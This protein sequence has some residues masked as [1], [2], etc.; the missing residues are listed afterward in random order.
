MEWREEYDGDP[1]VERPQQ[2]PDLVVIHPRGSSVFVEAMLSELRQIF[3]TH[4][5]SE[6]VRMEYD[7]NLYFGQLT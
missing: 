1:E 7:T 4:Q 5:Q 2:P 3:D 6:V